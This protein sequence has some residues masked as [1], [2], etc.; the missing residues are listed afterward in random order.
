MCWSRRELLSTLLNSPGQHWSVVLR[1][2]WVLGPALEVAALGEPPMQ[3]AIGTEQ[4]QAFGQVEVTLHF[5]V[6]REGS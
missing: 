4:C 1:W 5:R 2:G 6:L 3:E